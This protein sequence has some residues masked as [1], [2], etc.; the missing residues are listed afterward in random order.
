[1]KFFAATLATLVIASPAMARPTLDQYKTAKR[2][3]SDVL[4]AY[5]KGNKAE[6]CDLYIKSVD[7]REQTGVSKVW[8][9]TAGGSV[10]LVDLEHKQNENI[11]ALNAGTNKLGK[12][13]CGSRWV[14]RNLTTSYSRVS[15][16]SNGTILTGSGSS[17]SANIRNHCEKEWGTDYEMVAYCVKN[18]EEAARSLGY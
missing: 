17:V 8:P 4:T 5:E 6:V 9:V 13:L 15:S 11:V 18:Q 16:N 3:T 2:L 12:S 10:K 1:M 14:Y 7:Y